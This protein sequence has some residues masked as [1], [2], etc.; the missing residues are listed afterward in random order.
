[1][2]PKFPFQSGDTLL[3]DY[4]ERLLLHLHLGLDFHADLFQFLG[5]RVNEFRLIL[6]MM[7]QLAKRAVDGEAV[8]AILAV[9]VC[10]G[11]FFSKCGVGSVGKDS[12]RRQGLD[13]QFVYALNERSKLS[14]EQPLLVVVRAGKLDKVAGWRS[15]GARAGGGI[16][17]QGSD[18]DGRGLVGRV[19]CHCEWRGGSVRDDLYSVRDGGR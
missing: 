13:L 8:G 5:L 16:R 4:C 12:G 19:V 1:V 11:G 18:D 9:R 7:A 6:N 10:R 2:L 14:L 17:G 3:L 15:A